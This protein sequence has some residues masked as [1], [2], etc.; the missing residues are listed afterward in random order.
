MMIIFALIKVLTAIF[1]QKTMKTATA[2]EESMLVEKMKEKDVLIGS[3]S[4]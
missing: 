2:D 3:R 4:F 1:L